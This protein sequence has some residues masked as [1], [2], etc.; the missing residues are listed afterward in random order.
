MLAS[1][2]GRSAAWVCGLLAGRDS[3]E[4]GWAHSSDLADPTPFLEAGQPA[5]DHRDAVRP[6]TERRE[7]VRRLRRPAS[8]RPG[9]G[10]PR[11]RHRGGSLGTPEPGWW[12][13]CAAQ[14]LPL[15][16]VPYRTPF[17][18]LARRIADARAEQDHARDLWALDAQ[19]AL[20]LAALSAERIAVLGG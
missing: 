10:R 3:A 16:E 7:G 18:A 19:R 15:V 11:L 9:S 14:D 5:A 20:S 13:A 17:L 4:V 1:P 6:P 8:S 2:A 12:Q